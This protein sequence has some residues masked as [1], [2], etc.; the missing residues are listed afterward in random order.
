[1]FVIFDT[2]NMFTPPG[3]KNSGLKQSLTFFAIEMT[4]L[5]Q[6]QQPLDH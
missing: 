5:S 1:M 3:G 4:A 2:V 6:I